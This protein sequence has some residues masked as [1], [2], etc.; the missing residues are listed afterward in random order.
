METIDSPAVLLKG[1]G[2]NQTALPAMA[3]F[4]TSNQTTSVTWKNSNE[5]KVGV[6]FF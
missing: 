5:S 6:E 1:F 3:H 4:T 2:Q